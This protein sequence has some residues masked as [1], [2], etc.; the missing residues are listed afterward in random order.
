MP[1]LQVVSD[2]EPMADQGPAIDQLAHGVLSGDKLQVLL[3]I[4]G[5]GKTYVIAKVIEAVQR[6]TL[7][8]AHNKT[9]AAQLCMEFREFFPSNAVEFF[10]SYYDYYQPE[11][12]LAS[13]DT[14][15]EK[16]ASINEEIERLRHAATQ[17]LM[18]RR[19][20][21]IVASVSC[22]YGLGSPKEYREITLHVSV[23]QRADRDDILRQ[24]VKMQFVRNDLALERGT[25]RV[26]GDV[27]EI[28]PVDEDIITRIELWGDE[29]ERISHVEELTGEIIGQ[30]DST[31]IFPTSHFVTSGER[32]QRAMETIT[33]ELDERVAWF[34]AHGKLLEAQRLQ[35][36]TQYDLEM[37]R[38]IGYCQGIENYSRHLDGRQPGEAPSTLMDYFPD[39]FLLVADESHQSLPQIR[40]MYHGD[41]S[42]K[43]SLVEHGF[44][45]PSAYDNR[46]LTFTEWERRVN[47]VICTSATPGT[48]EVEHADRLVEVVIRPTGLLDPEI[49]VRPTRGQVDD[50]IAEI[51]KRIEKKQRV[52]VTTLTKRMAED[53][54]EYLADMQIRVHYLHS[55]VVAMERTELLRDLRLG[56]YDVLVGIN[57]LREG[58]D[59]P[60]VSLVAILDA[61]RQGFLR[62]ET[63]LMQTMGRAARHEN[64]RVIMYADT[65]S[66]AMRVAI[67][68]TQR[69]RATQAAYNEEHGIVPHTVNKAIRDTIRSMTEGQQTQ[70]VLRPEAAS[71]MEPDDVRDIIAALEVE[72][73]K[74]AE[75]LDFER[76]ADLRDEIK[77]LQSM[78]DK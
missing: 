65:I 63:S 2:Y 42:R 71:E 31:I 27:I 78:L 17:A 32:L 54:S 12:Y 15:I 53:L 19:D 8:L 16:D 10:I 52:L 64:G 25:F 9:L 13:T 43:D 49:E 33:Q 76:A 35:Q 6:P 44:R 22:I 11:A 5:S 7:V 18:T 57:L 61:D 40:G 45:M 72:M 60:E 14:Y 20:V 29:I 58:L 3:G 36:R 50:L 59:L 51:K 69:R 66:P 26:R 28:H 23:G 74:A 41:R 70:R 39:D 47:Q 55:D 75:D 48:Y 30:Q 46:P 21:I 38:E 34:T 56:K 37:I 68:E 4:T 24:L 67:D 73:Q 77:E 1:K 62:S